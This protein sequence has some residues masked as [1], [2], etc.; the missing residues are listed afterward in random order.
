MEPG[1]PYALRLDGDVPFDTSASNIPLPQVPP[2][3]LQPKIMLSS[4]LPSL[5]ARDFVE[6]LLCEDPK[7]RLGCGFEG[8]DEVRMHPWFRSIDW[9][10][11]VRREGGYALKM[12]GDNRR[13]PFDQSEAVEAARGVAGFSGATGV[14]GLGNQH[15]LLP[16][17]LRPET[18]GMMD[19]KRLSS[20][21]LGARRS[22]SAMRSSGRVRAIWTMR[23]RSNAAGRALS[24]AQ[25][26]PGGN[27]P[28]SDGDV[29]GFA[30]S[31]TQGGFQ[32]RRMGAPRASNA[33]GAP[34]AMPRASFGTSPRLSMGDGKMRRSS[35]LGR[36]GRSGPNGSFGGR[37]SM[38][39]PGVSGRASL[40]LLGPSSRKSLEAMPGRRGSIERA[41]S[42]D[43]LTIE[44][45]E[46]VEIPFRKSLE[47]AASRRESVL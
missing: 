11:L 18:A 15:E 33:V 16:G 34:V 5:E 32:A 31:S 39:L 2:Q 38:E 14:L 29:F 8:F 42:G 27:M 37:R 45:G 20:R 19:S 7:E 35:R 3:S 36:S 21:G 46:D 26:V 28:P 4:E 17:A 41:K 43:F 25:N 47:M 12:L 44:V 1:S 40:D 10:D 24:L 9:D 30:F 22:S 6:G 23:R 13:S